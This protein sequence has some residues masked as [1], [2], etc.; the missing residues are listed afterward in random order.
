[1]YIVLAIEIVEGA[2]SH[3]FHS[4]IMSPEE[5]TDSDRYAYFVRFESAPK[6]PSHTACDVL[7]TV[8]RLHTCSIFGP[9]YSQNQISIHIIESRIGQE[10]ALF[11]LIH[12]TVKC[13]GCCM[14]EIA[15]KTISMRDDRDT[16]INSQPPFCVKWFNFPNQASKR[17]P[18]YNSSSTRTGYVHTY[19]V[20]V[21]SKH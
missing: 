13:T 7:S 19:Y 16:Q 20:V 15:L 14:E 5:K 18:V 11:R 9:Q 6:N 2:N 3:G 1:M 4:I 12:C 17:P 10:S 8:T 21:E